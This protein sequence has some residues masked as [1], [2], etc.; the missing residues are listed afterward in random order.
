MFQV[1]LSYKINVLDALLMDVILESPIMVSDTHDNEMLSPR[2]LVV[3]FKPGINR[4]GKLAQSIILSLVY[5]SSYDKCV[6]S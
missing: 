6:F 3:K 4:L 2:T 5:F 1:V